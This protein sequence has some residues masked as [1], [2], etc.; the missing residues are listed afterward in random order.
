MLLKRGLYHMKE[1]RNHGFRIRFYFG[2]ILIIAACVIGFFNFQKPDAK[3]IYEEGKAL[4]FSSSNDDKESV[5]KITDISTEPVITVDKG[6]SY[7][8]IVEYEKEATSKGKEPGYI[9]L[10]LTKEDGDKLVAKADKL[11][12]NP[13]YIYGTIIYAYRNKSAIKQYSDLITQAFHNYNL[14]QANP[15]TA[16]YFS[17]TEASSAKRGGLMVAAGLTIAGLVFIGLAFLK[18][19]KVGAA[20]DEMYAA[21]P[22]LRGNLDL[23]RTNATYADDEMFVYIYKNHFFTTWSGLEVYDLTKANRVYHY[24]L[25]HKR[26]GITTNIESFIIFLSDDRSYKGKKKKIE[27]KNIGEETDDF[28]QPFFRAVAQEFPNV[29]VGYEN[30]RPF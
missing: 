5:L 29:A 11:Q 20:Y 25:T 6:K 1:N 26:Y 16:F 21:Y 3:K 22:E 8:Y 28:L 10:E 23:L 7:V 30:N 4:N 24:Q 15:E 9:G 13:E 14:L 12:D 17:Q 2:L 27:I 19:K 18:R